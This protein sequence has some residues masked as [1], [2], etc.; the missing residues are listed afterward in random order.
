[1]RK[2]IVAAIAFE[3]VCTAAFAT[4]LHRH[5]KEK[6]AEPTSSMIKTVPQSATL[7]YRVGGQL[8]Q[9]LSISPGT[10]QITVKRLN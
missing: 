5:M 3:L 9:S 4:T 1:M 2:L 7:E 6:A 8:I 10:Y